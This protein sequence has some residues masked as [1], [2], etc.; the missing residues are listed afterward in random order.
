MFRCPAFS[1]YFLFP[2]RS[3][4]ILPISDL[5]ICTIFSPSVLHSLWNLKYQEWQLQWIQSSH[6]VNPN[7]NPRTSDSMMIWTSSLQQL[8]V[9]WIWND[10]TVNTVRI[11]LET[12][13]VSLP[14]QHWIIGG[15]I[16][17]V[18]LNNITALLGVNCSK[19]QINPENINMQS[20]TN[21]DVCICTSKAISLAP[22]INVL[23][24]RVC[25]QLI[26]TLYK[27]W[28]TVGVVRTADLK[29]RKK[30]RLIQWT[31]YS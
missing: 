27:R 11:R 19:C 10:V 24:S 31:P 1:Q 17:V 18:D 12:A 25:C 2:T 26:S 21:K 8:F 22:G 3:Y 29:S 6:W 13:T 9:H 28:I 20:C 7:R 30:T 16:E 14:I 15:P 4:T 5:N 23:I